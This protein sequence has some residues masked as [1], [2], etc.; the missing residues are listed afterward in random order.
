MEKST[1]RELWV[2]YIHPVN[3]TLAVQW[4]S[5]DDLNSAE[6]KAEAFIN[7][8]SQCKPGTGKI[9]YNPVTGLL[10]K[11]AEEAIKFYKP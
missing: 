11:T 3:R 6:Q 9:V 5:S 7:N 2:G 8:V 10:V 4:F 1:N